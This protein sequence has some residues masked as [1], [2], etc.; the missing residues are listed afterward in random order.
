MRIQVFI[1]MFALESYLCIDLTYTVEEGKNPRTLVADIAADSQIMDDVLPEEHKL[2]TFNQLQGGTGS[3]QYF[4]VSKK[5]GKLYT[6]VTLDAEAMCKRKKE[7][8]QIV[9]V[10][11]QRQHLLLEY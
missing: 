10:A 11:V 9:D 5:T 4:Q 8:F 3:S 2:I 7:C 6:S 1:L